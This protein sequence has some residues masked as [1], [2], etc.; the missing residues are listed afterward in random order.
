MYNAIKDFVK[1]KK[2]VYDRVFKY[3]DPV[4]DK[5]ETIYKIDPMNYM[6][7]IFARSQNRGTKNTI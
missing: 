3:T 4:S 7:R 2:K 6:K 5:V 1:F